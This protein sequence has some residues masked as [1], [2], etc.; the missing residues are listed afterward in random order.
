M[1]VHP[2]LV[3]IRFYEEGVDV[4]KPLYKMKEKYKGVGNILI[5]EEGTARVS[6]L[7]SKNFTKKDFNAVQDY[8]KSLEIKKMIYK[9]KGK[10]NVIE[11][12]Y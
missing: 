11:L 9:H 1:H 7:I 8:L 4:S 12:N 5:D 6:L 2:S 10:I 3:Q